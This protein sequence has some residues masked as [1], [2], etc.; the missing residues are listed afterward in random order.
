MNDLRFKRKYFAMIT[1]GK[2]NL[3][4]RLDYPFIKKMKVGEVVRFFW[5]DEKYDVKII[6]IRR[7]KSFTEMLQ[8]EDV[9]KLVPG[10]SKEE[11]LLEY[12]A[13]YPDWKVKKTGGVVIL[14]FIP[15][16]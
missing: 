5:E 8:K 2:K 3:E 15:V 10:M 16:K 9:V 1:S 12:Q 13:I 7:Y 11:A 14:E 6:A 4:C